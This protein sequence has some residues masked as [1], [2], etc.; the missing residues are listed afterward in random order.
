MINFDPISQIK[1][2]TLDGKGL[3]DLLSIPCRD[4]KLDTIVRDKT[5]HIT[6]ETSDCTIQFHNSDYIVT[7]A[8]PSRLTRSQFDFDG[9]LLGRQVHCTRP[10][11]K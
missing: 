2:G 10:G 7:I 4:E 8:F 3:L 5:V 9:N 11:R 1:Q 6:G